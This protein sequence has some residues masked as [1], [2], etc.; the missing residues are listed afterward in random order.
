MDSQKISLL[1][2]QFEA[3]VNEYEGVEFWMA[4]DLQKLLGYAK[5]QN[6]EKVIEKAKESCAKAGETLPDHFTDVSK[7]IDAGKGAKHEISDIMLTRYACYLISQNGD[8]RKEAVAFAQSYFAVQTRKQELVEERLELNRRL[9]AR[10]RLTKSEKELSK[11]IYE[12]GVDQQGFARIRSKGDKVLFGGKST[13]DMKLKLDVPKNRP[14]A[15]FLPTVTI[16]AKFF[17]NE[18]TN[19]NIKNKD[20]YGEESITQQHLSSNET[21][22]EALLKEGIKP[23]ELPPA[24]DIKRVE[25]RVN[26]ADKKLLKSEKSKK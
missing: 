16:A 13:A 10:K 14:L 15:D 9:S 6:F 18:I 8:P 19:V 23:E 26:A 22:R 11:L 21:V 20:L 25:R 3:I 5:W 7:V 4:R 2:E 1:R 17:S 12:R 24:E